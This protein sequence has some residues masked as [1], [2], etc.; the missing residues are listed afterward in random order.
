MLDKIHE[1][2]K[3][4]LRP[5]FNDP[6]FKA[7]ADMLNNPKLEVCPERPKIFRA[8]EAPISNLRVVIVG[9][10]PYPT[11]LL[12]TGLAF[13]IP[14][15][16]P[17]GQWP[18]S[19]RIIA[20]SIQPMYPSSPAELYFHEGLEYWEF[21]GVL[22]LNR[23]LTCFPNQPGSQANLWSWFTLE[24]IKELD[25]A[26][27][28]LVYYFLGAKAQELEGVVLQAKAIFKDVHPSY[29]ARQRSEGK[30]AQMNG[31]WKEITDITYQEKKAGISWWLPF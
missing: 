1:E 21:Q 24:L 18:A 12:A 3:P 17:I 31:H 16:I 7:I 2:W 10:D 27:P 28:G 11:N 15:G 25:K 9:Q 22:L 8:F 19:L 20:E 5:L 26:K 4:L 6:R 30:Q 13:A 23:Y 14:S 29:V